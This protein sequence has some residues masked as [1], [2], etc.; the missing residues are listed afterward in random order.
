MD[1]ECYEGRSRQTPARATGNHSHET[2]RMDKTFWHAKWQRNE[3]GFH[4]PQ[5]NALLIR[6]FPALHL[7]RGAR[8]FV[9]LCG[10]S[11]DIHWLL[12]QGYQVVG[13]ELSPLAVRQ[14]F[15]ELGLTPHV[16]TCGR[17]TRY[18]TGELCVFAGDI[19]DLTPDMMGR[20]DGVYDRAAL[21]ALPPALRDAYA[22][23]LP[24]LTRSAPQLLV[25]LDY[26]QS[27]RAGPPFSVD[28]AEVRQYYAAL[29]NPVCLA[30]V[31]VPGGLKGICPAREVVW[32][33][34]P[35]R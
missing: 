10:K 29:F 11:L 32:H 15:A 21:I 6:H 24:A 9:P 14:L 30:T 34:I 25:C 19:F 8:V 22:A 7:S 18:M 31:P 12:A 26:D 5:P 33:L 28:A 13:C 16:S 35:I 23:H 17:V 2:G 3:I 4:E 27:C 20:V 1:K